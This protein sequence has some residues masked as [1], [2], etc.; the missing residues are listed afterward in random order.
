[1]KL[2]DAVYWITKNTGIHWLVKTI[3]KLLGKDCGCDE[4]RQ[5]WNKYEFK[6]STDES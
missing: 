3:S 2:G 1:M 5:R 6:R 4:R